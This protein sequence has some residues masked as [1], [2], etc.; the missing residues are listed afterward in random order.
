MMKRIVFWLPLLVLFFMN[1][2]E[3]RQDVPDTTAAFPVA[4]AQETPQAYVLYVVD[5]YGEPVPGTYVNFCTDR[6]CTLAQSDENGVIT[7]EG[8][9]D[10]Y[11]IQLLKVPEGFSFDP[12]FELY[13]G[14]A[15]GEW[16][17]RIRRDAA[18]EAGR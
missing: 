4:I 6:T 9:P 7:F 15:Y 17:L 11:H 12:E 5:Q 10:S 16:Q 13:T 2:C 14:Q 3:L 1:G 8:A 18:G